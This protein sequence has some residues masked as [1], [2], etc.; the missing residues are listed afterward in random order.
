M[1]LTVQ[2]LMLEGL[3]APKK[4]QEM[5][6]QKARYEAQP[7]CLQEHSVTGYDAGSA[8]VANEGAGCPILHLNHKPFFL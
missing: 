7:T 1:N 3:F 5:G 8:H 6:C 4:A 2:L